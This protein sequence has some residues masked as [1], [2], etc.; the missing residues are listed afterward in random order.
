MARSFGRNPVWEKDLPNAPELEDRLAF[1]LR[2]RSIAGLMRDVTVEINPWGAYRIEENGKVAGAAMILRAATVNEQGWIVEAAIPLTLLR[3]NRNQ[4]A[5]QVQ[6]SVEQIRSRRALEPE[7]RWAGTLPPLRLAAGAEANG[8]P[9]LRASPM[10]NP[11]PPLEVGRV[12]RAPAVLADWLDPAWKDVPEFSLA[13]NEASPRPARYQTRV[14]WMHDG[15]NLALF[16]YV[17][18]PEPIL[19]YAS[20][21]DR[22]FTSGGE[23]IAGGEDHVAVRLATSGSAYLEIGFSP[24]G[25]I[26]DAIGRGPRLM[27]P[28]SS[29]NATIDAKADVRR[30][31][32]LVRANVPLAECAAA[33]GESGVP[34]EWRILLSRYRAERPGEAPEVTSLPVLDGTASFRGAIRYQRMLL[35]DAPPNAVRVP[36]DGAAPLPVS[37]L[38]GEIA[39]LDSNAWTPLERRSRRLRTM[40]PRDIASR[41]EDAVRAERKAW[42][43]VTA[44]EQWEEFRDTRMQGL[45]DSLG[46]FPPAAAPLDIRVTGRYEGDGY[47]LENVV[48]Q[49]RRGFYIPANLYLP[50]KPDAAAPAILL[51]HSHHYP[52]SEPELHDAGEL[53]ARAGAAVLVMERPGFGER[54]ETNPWFR[55]AYASRFHFSQQLALAGESLSAWTAWDVMRCVD[56]LLTRPG[57]DPKR[58]IVVGSV[59]SGGEAAALAAALDTRIAAVVP[60][61]Y[62]QGHL[63]VHGDSV[64]QVAKQFSPWLVSASVAPRKF[65]RA[66]EFG[67]EASEESDVPGLWVDGMS[68]SEKVWG[69]YDA[70]GSLAEAQG[71]GFLRAPAERRSAC[72]NVGPEQREALYPTFQRWF[73]IPYPSD[74]DRAIPPSSLLSVNLTREASRQHEALR[75]RPSSGLVSIP[76]GTAKDLP[77]TPMHRLVLEMS[78]DLLKSA[79]ARRQSIPSKLRAEALRKDLAPLLGDIEPSA[80]LDVKTAWSRTLTGV[81]V[82]AITLRVERKIWVPLVLLAP[83]SKAPNGVVLGVS[84]GGKDRFLKGRSREIAAILEAGFAVCLPDL[85]GTGETESGEGI[86]PYGGLAQQEMDLSQNLLGARLRDL[87]S[88]L[89]YLRQRPDGERIPIAIWGESFATPNS[90]HLYLDEI[91]EQAGP[92]LQRRADP[93]GPHL[94]LLAGLYEEGLRAIAARGALAGYLNVL[95]SPYTYVP[96]DLTVWGMLKAGDISDI[97]EAIA[98]RALM[99]SSLVDGRN[100]LVPHE[101]AAAL[102]SKAKD[103]YRQAGAP[104]RFALGGESTADSVAWLIQNIR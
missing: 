75:L 52:K 84:G 7:Y 1:R 92:E 85:R 100:V 15:Q 10:G 35:Q 56:F 19:A 99:L 93:L 74:K 23:A 3:L 45:R 42:E 69:F 34:N 60:F 98:P 59:A 14:K 33:L 53:W 22:G 78:R 8:N 36:E 30:G 90:E 61:N 47:R 63:R 24:T 11:R 81:H 54:T 101:T 68:R 17:E 104:S 27:R 51:V 18:E 57:I 2:Y 79:R 89:A 86:A 77:R 46:A 91:E 62:D 38:A 21:R 95:E 28:D 43:Q 58:I 12:P 25:A 70:S 71:F 26:R 88:V 102:Y 50:K 80:S 48:F 103:A 55:Q 49:S 4:E 67:W 39:R 13:R 40:L 96:S 16:F 72:E 32:W 37:G 66:F 82:E 83:A 73:G 64:G 31:H 41:T 87:R 97:A 9:E 76:P 20:G 5:A 44:K 29:W 65:I 94:A 6:L